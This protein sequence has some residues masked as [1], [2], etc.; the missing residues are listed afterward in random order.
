MGQT[1]IASSTARWA[2]GKFTDLSN[3]TLAKTNCNASLCGAIDSSE[4]LRESRLAL[5]LLELRSLLPLSACLILELVDR[6][7]RT[8]VHRC[9]AHE[10]VGCEACRRC[11]VARGHR[12]TFAVRLRTT[13]WSRGRHASRASDRRRRTESMLPPRRLMVALDHSP[14]PRS[15]RYL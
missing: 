14:S 6:R 13:R 2:T 4:L 8:F 10:C 12:R 11:W 1:I 5:D 15:H 9:Q 7:G 3:S